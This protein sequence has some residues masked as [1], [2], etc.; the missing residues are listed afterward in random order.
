MEVG[1][2]HE[3]VLT[4]MSTHRARRGER[5]R[6][7]MPSR[8]ATLI[9]PFARVLSA[10]NCHR[11]INRS[12]RTYLHDTWDGSQLLAHSI[13][14][15]SEGKATWLASRARPDMAVAVRRECGHHMW[16]GR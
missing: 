4:T 12:S 9:N 14:A 10:R 5:P 2:R 6:C 7:S 1:A 11:A 13:S 15:H 16:P 8:H 3:S